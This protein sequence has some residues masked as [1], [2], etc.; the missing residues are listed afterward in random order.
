MTIADEGTD[1]CEEVR[2]RVM[3]CERRLQELD[4]RTD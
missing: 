1:G 3:S 2:E 4:L